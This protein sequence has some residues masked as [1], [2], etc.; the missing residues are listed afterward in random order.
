[1]GRAGALQALLR[2]AWALI[3]EH[4]RL[5]RSHWRALV[6]NS[7]QAVISRLFATKGFATYSASLDYQSRLAWVATP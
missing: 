4:E 5:G 6:R 3:Y 1:M 7:D 2:D